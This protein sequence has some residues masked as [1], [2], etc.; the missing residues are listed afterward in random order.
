MAGKGSHA[1]PAKG[2]SD[3]RQDAVKLASDKRGRKVVDLHAVFHKTAAKVL[4]LALAG[5]TQQAIRELESGGSFT[6][7]SLNLTSAMVSWK[8]SLS[9]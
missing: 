6:L 5:S 7:A 9:S 4:A 1:A 8:S 3:P 2:A